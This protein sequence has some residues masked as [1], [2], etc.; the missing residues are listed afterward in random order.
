[1]QSLMSKAV[2]SDFK[3]IFEDVVIYI[4]KSPL[5]VCLS[6]EGFVLDI[7]SWRYRLFSRI[8]ELLVLTAVT[9]VIC[10]ISR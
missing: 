7:Y 4:K 8:F 2:F 9:R 10:V 1:M 3:N 6:S 5:V